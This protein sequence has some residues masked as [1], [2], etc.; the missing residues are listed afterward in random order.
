ML[1]SFSGMLSW[2]GT[3]NG[4]CSLEHS[5]SDRNFIQGKLATDIK[6]TNKNVVFHLILVVVVAFFYSHHFELIFNQSFIMLSL[7]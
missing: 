7:H 3:I 1:F 2:F 4:Y 5:C 6:Y